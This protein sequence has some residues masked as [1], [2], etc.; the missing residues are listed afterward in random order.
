MKLKDDLHQ[1]LDNLLVDGLPDLVSPVDLARKLPNRSY[2]RR[3]LPIAIGRW[4][5]SVGAE[6]HNRLTKD[7]ETAITIW[8]LRDHDRY[9]RMGPSGRLRFYQDTCAQA[10]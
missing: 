5:R 6:Q 10:L 8:S 3:G 7:S 9:R 2:S 1:H 4:L